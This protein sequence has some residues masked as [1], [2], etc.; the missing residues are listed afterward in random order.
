[1]DDAIG[2]MAYAISVSIAKMIQ[3]G[4]A[5]NIMTTIV[6]PLLEIVLSLLAG[7]VCLVRW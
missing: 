1:M 6:D 4:D 3:N 7:G 5:S 2:L